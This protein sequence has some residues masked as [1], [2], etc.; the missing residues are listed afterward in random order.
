[1]GLPALAVVLGAFASFSGFLFGYDTGYISG[2]KEMESF[3]RTFGTMQPDGSYLLGSGRDSLITSI[4]SVGTCLGALCGSIVGDR[5]GRRFG[6]I[7]YICL[8]FI[9][10]ACQTGCKSLAG[11]AIGRVFAGLGVGGTSCLVPLYQA[12]CSPKSIRGLVVSA[13][14][15]FVTVGLLV[16]ACVV[17]ATKDRADNS[18]YEI[19]IGIQFVW[20]ALIIGGM[21]LLPESPRWLLSRDNHAKAKKSL[22]RLLGQPEDSQAVTTE[23]AEIAANLE[24]ERS[25]GKASWADCFK[26]GE[27]KTRLRIFTGMALQALQQLTGVNFIFYYGTSFF[28]NSGISNPFLTTIATN[29]VN[30]GMSVVGMLAADRVGRRPLMMYGA[31]G[32]AVSQLIV[33]AVGVAVS[34]ANQAGQ[35]VLVAFCCIYI[36]HFASTWGTLAWVITSEIYPYELRGKGMSLSTAT[37][38]LFNFAIGYATPYLVDEAPGS[39]G[40]KTNVF[41]IWGGCCCI[42]FVFAY[43]FIPETKELS[44]EQ[45]DL[46]YRNSTIL[47]SAAYRRQILQHDIHDDEIMHYSANKGPRTQHIEEDAKQSSRPET[48]A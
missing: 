26:Y 18:A 8:F 31:A 24:H 2:C 12:E 21:C 48:I 32:M 5:I 20:G 25:V 28:A 23:F 10:V 11:F 9:G 4:L 3:I 35:K 33:A 15:F 7:F 1:M 38:W 39:A 22:S 19:P 46:L 40:L 6:I 30:V 27:G 43:F 29:V 47:K 44:L 34:Q 17:Y 14:Q 36:A 45:C 41:W 42:A 37:Q 16:A 13:Y